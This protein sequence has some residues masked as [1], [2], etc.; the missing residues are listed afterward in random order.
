MGTRPPCQLS[1]ARRVTVPSTS[2][3]TYRPVP[4]GWSSAP[5]LRWTM[6]MVKSRGRRESA[7]FSRMRSVYRPLA[8]QEA[9]FWLRTAKQVL[10]WACWME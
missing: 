4:G 5:V 10:L 1:L 3:T 7:L 2:S 8:V 6:G 9:M